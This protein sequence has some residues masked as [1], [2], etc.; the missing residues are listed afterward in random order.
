MKWNAVIFGPNDTPFEDGTFR[1]QITF[2]GDYPH[3]PPKVKFVSKMFHP[4]IY[5]DGSICLDVLQSRWSP[6]YDVAAILTSIQS[7]LD[8]PNPIS[9]ANAEAANLYQTNKREYQKRVAT[10]V[11]QSWESLDEDIDEDLDDNFDSL[12]E[13]V[14]ADDDE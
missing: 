13:L 3:K 2:T 5:L 4:N 7:L 1:L 12:P 11:Q 8:E 10:T 6:T 14:G 9:P